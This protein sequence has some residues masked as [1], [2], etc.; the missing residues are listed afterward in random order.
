VCRQ[1]GYACYGKPV[2]LRAAKG[3]PRHYAYYRC[4]GSDAY[5]FGG[6]RVCT[7]RQVRTDRLDMAVW[8]QVE[9]LVQ[10]P[11]RLTA[12]YQ[13][14]LEEACR[15]PTG[16]DGVA[17][18]ETQIAKLRRGVGRLIDSYA[19]GTIEKV[20]FEPRIRGLKER[21]ARLEEQRQALADR[22]EL[23]ATL[24]LIIG[25]MEDFA[26]TVRSR[27][28]ALDWTGRRDLI[29]TLVKRVEIGPEEV[30]VVFRVAPTS[31]EPEPTGS[32]TD[33]GFG[34]RSLQ[35]CGRRGLAVARQRV[36]ARTRLLSGEA[37]RVTAQPTP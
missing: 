19:E 17:A 11:A 8:Q 27:L 24:S 22:T 26:R 12:E 1:C 3:R 34:G 20:E 13:R 10:D 35:D 9:Q 18:L 15:P 37:P 29:R 21:L 25:R 2:S 28:A 7:N 6:Q 30:N 16:R 4:C 36:P 14:R 5:R 23:Q 33:P 32:S 31:A